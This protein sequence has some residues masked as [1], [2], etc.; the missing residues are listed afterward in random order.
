ML[1]V[2]SL[3][4]GLYTLW[5]C[6]VVVFVCVCSGFGKLDYLE[7]IYWEYNV[8]YSSNLQYCCIIDWERVYKTA[9][10][11]VQVLQNRISKCITFTYEIS[12]SS[13]VIKIKF[14]KCLIYTNSICQILCTSVMPISSD[15]VAAV[16][17]ETETWLKFRDE[18]ETETL[19]KKPRPRPGSSRP[20]PIL[21]TLHFSDGN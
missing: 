20:R 1:Y 21:E 17:S 7:L 18:T 8:D 16:T 3:C 9:V 4:C 15:V 19:S 12:S 13:N 14:S 2:C 11:P 6:W 10:K 5:W